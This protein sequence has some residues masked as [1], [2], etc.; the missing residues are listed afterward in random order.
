VKLLN[1]R[2]G[3]DDAR[4]AAALRSD[5][6]RLSDVVRDAIRDTYERRLRGRRQR[7]RPSAILAEIYAA[8]PDPPG[9]PARDYDV[10]DR[11]ATRDAIRRK[12]RR[13]GR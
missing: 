11:R 5:G 10:H 1:V 13:G 9:S 4:M 8:Y 2:L 7:R 6:V 12:L 3:P